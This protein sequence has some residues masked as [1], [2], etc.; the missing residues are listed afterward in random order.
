MTALSARKNDNQN[1]MYATLLV[2][3]TFV[4]TYLE[5]QISVEELFFFYYILR[6]EARKKSWG[7]I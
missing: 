2:R 4:Y 1:G 3:M 6:I 5:D 7:Y